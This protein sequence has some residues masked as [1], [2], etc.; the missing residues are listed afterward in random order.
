MTLDTIRVVLAHDHP[1]VGA[2]MHILEEVRHLFE[3]L[4]PDILLL[5]MTLADEPGSMPDHEVKASLAAA[6]VFVLRGYQNRAYVFGMLTD[7]SAT[8]LG[9][10]DALQLIA[11]SIQVGVAGAGGRRSHRIVAKLP[12]RE[13]KGAPAP[14]PDLTAREVEVLRQL[15]TGKSDQAIGQHLGISRAT[16]RYHLQHI[17]A[18]LGVKRRSEAIAWAAHAG[19]GE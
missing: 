10:L 12:T 11:E 15:T 7:E 6:R 19:W 13:L 14:A 1:V 17:Y 5:E 3:D 2:G 18:K 9:E 4:M 16:V 8:A